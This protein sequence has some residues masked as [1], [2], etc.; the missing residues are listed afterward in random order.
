MMPGWTELNDGVVE[1]YADATAHAD[2]HPFTIHCLQ[3]LLKMVYYVSCHK[4]YPLLR[5]DHCFQPGPFGLKLFPDTLLLAFSYLFKLGVYVWFFVLFQFYFGQAT[6]IK[7]TNGGAVDHCL[8]YII[9]ANVISEYCR[10]ASVCFLYRC[11][12]ETYE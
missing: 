11:S 5:A 12:G 7:D 10:S 4:V 3:A 9:D 1:V 8:L 2:Y 6:L